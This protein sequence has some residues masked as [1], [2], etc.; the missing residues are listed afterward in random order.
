[1]GGEDGIG[2]ARERDSYISNF[3]KCA[4][5]AENAETHGAISPRRPLRMIRARSQGAASRKEEKDDLC[6]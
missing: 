1:M 3:A 6:M 2:T 5:L 4:Y